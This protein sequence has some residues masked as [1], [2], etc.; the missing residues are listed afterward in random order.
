MSN[1]K[2]VYWVCVD[3]NSQ[4]EEALN[5]EPFLA[6]RSPTGEWLVEMVILRKDK[7][8]RMKYWRAFRREEIMFA[9]D[10]R[11]LLESAL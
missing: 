6:Y 11:A 3:I 1:I 9:E 4:A 10:F 5:Q 2:K 7:T 8:V